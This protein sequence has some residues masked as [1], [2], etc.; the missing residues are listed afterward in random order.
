LWQ[1]PEYVILSLS[2]G[3]RPS[4]FNVSELNI[5][6][7]ITEA[8]A[9]VTRI[10]GKEIRYAT[11]AAAALPHTDDYRNFTIL[12]VEKIAQAIKTGKWY[13]VATVVD[14]DDGNVEKVRSLHV[15]GIM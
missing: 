3:T 13:F 11:A 8:T 12:A 1:G 9:I 7:N 2:G 4:P 6:M 10:L 15:E 14:H 5:Q